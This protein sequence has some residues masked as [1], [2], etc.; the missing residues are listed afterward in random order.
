M[1]PAV[2]VVASALQNLGDPVYGLEIVRAIQDTGKLEDIICCQKSQGIWRITT[3]TKSDRAKLLLSGIT[4]RGHAITVLGSSPRLVNGMETIRLNIGNVPYE[5]PDTDVQAALDILGLKFGSSIQYEFYKDE[6]KNPTKVKTG[7]RWVPIVKPSQ[8]LPE[9]IK[10]A[11]KYRAY[12]QYNRKDTHGTD[13]KPKQNPSDGDHSDNG[14]NPAWTWPPHSWRRPDSSDGCNQNNTDKQS[15]DDLNN[16]NNLRWPPTPSGW[17]KAGS[18]HGLNQSPPSDYDSEEDLSNLPTATPLFGW[19]P[20]PR[21]GF[22]PSPTDTES[23]ADSR[24]E[25]QANLETLLNSNSAKHSSSSGPSDIMS[26]WSGQGF[27]AAKPLLSSSLTPQD[28]QS[29]VTDEKLD[30]DLCEEEHYL[31]QT[32]LKTL[33]EDI[34]IAYEGNELTTPCVDSNNASCVESSHNDKHTTN[35][36]SKLTLPLVVNESYESYVITSH[37]KADS[38]SISVQGGE[39]ASHSSSA[40]ND[41]RNVVVKSV[42]STKDKTIVEMGVDCTIPNTISVIVPQPSSYEKNSQNGTDTQEQEINLGGQLSMHQFLTPESRSRPRVKED[43]TDSRRRSSSK[44]KGGSPKGTPKI[45]KQN[46]NKNSPKNHGNVSEITKDSVSANRETVSKEKVLEV[47][48]AAGNVD[49]PSQ[50]M[51]WWLNQPSLS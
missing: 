27:W 43:M 33:C 37:N 34:G 18:D 29:R 42:S 26:G 32:S 51:D 14:D 40:H 1:I 31:S 25:I 39:I 20:G 45:K 44:R 21:E 50:T 12:L 9:W 4:I 22:P 23:V 48:S 30:S 13:P 10:V 15:E 16:L 46:K 11:D 28:T 6:K 47:P 8:P 35:P 2:F 41:N 3:K 24:L 19:Q 7:R 38:G 17:W 36:T 5:P 49:Q